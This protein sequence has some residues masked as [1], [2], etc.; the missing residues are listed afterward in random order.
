MQNF[1]PKPTLKTVCTIGLL[2]AITALLSIFCTFRIGTIVKIPTK[3]ISVFVTASLFGPL[4]GGLVGATG[5][6]LNCLLAP[7]GPIIPQITAIEFLSGFVYGVFFFKS[8]IS[9]RSYIIRTVLCVV[10]QF[11]IDMLLTTGLFVQ[12]GWY[13]TFYAGFATRL[14]A[15]IIK[16]FLQ[17]A[18]ILT[19][20]KYLE[21]FRQITIG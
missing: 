17:S 14:L 2:I 12:L 10:V 15:G 18:V 1:F 7:S 11:V 13:P 6:L 21:Q 19:M 9:R 20:R 8:S 5:D 3:F 16:L 4:L